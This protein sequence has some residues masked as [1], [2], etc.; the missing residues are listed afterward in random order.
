MNFLATGLFRL[1]AMGVGKLIDKNTVTETCIDNNPPPKVLSKNSTFDTLY[2]M[3]MI[4]VSCLFGL[5]AVIAI[6]ILVC[7]IGY[8]VLEFIVKILTH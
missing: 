5:L 2:L 3:V 7:F 1:A 8:N 6:F 4:P